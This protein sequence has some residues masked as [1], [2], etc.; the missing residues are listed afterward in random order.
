MSGRPG[1][2]LDGLSP[3]EAM[4]FLRLLLLFISNEDGED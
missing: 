2:K 3:V 1:P 4:Q